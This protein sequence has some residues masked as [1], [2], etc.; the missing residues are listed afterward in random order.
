MIKKKD[1]ALLETNEL[2]LTGIPLKLFYYFDKVFLNFAKEFKAQEFYFPQ[3]LPLEFLEKIDYLESFPHLAIFTSTIKKEELS[4]ITRSEKIS[5]KLTF[6]SNLLTS[7]SCYHYFQYLEGKTLSSEVI[8]TT[9]NRCF[10]NEDF[11]SEQRLSSFSMREIIFLGNKEFVEEIRMVLLK[12]TEVFAERLGLK[13]KIEQSQDP[14]FLP[15]AK[16]KHILQRLH[17]YKYEL[18]VENGS[19]EPLAISSFNNHSDFFVNK[20]KIK[21]KVDNP[22]SGC[23]AFGLERWVWSFLTTHGDSPGNWPKSV[24]LNL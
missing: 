13:F 7:A 11:N 18:R 12:K 10:R 22:A 6:T 17:P 19:A 5:E 2:A 21:L 9:I 16:G 8:G 23:V 20:L 24:K 15:L 3:Y 1:I 4:K 14:F